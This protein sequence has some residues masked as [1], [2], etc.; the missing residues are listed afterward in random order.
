M[1]LVS[2]FLCLL[3]FTQWRLLGNA[4]P[5][6]GQTYM[7]LLETH[8]NRPFVWN[9]TSTC[10]AMTHTINWPADDKAADLGTTNIN[11]LVLPLSAVCAALCRSWD[12]IPQE[13]SAFGVTSGL[14]DGQR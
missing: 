6:A 13:D 8:Q 3:L 2:V 5:P 9:S 14:A 12:N 7:E 10:T 4:V 1:Q 11:F